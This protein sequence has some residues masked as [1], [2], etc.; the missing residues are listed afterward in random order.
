[1]P[2]IHVISVRFVK[3]HSLAS[4]RYSESQFTVLERRITGQFAQ[5]FSLK[6]S[7]SA[8]RA[9]LGEKYSSGSEFVL[10]ETVSHGVDTT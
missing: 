5:D 7:V 8:Q 9:A 10:S 1:M 6:M 3:M 2:Y 4:C